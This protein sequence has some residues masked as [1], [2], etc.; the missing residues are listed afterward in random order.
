MICDEKDLVW[1]REALQKRSCYEVKPSWNDPTEQNMRHEDD[2]GEP[3]WLYYPRANANSL[4]HAKRF[5]ESGWEKIDE[6]WGS[7]SKSTG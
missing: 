6:S 2:K 7:D 3:M 5:Q 1:Q 4:L